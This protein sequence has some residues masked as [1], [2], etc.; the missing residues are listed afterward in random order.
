[1][2]RHPSTN[3]ARTTFN[4]VQAAHTPCA[5]PNPCMY[6]ATSGQ[7]SVQF[8]LLGCA[9]VGPISVLHTLSH[10]EFGVCLSQLC[11]ERSLTAPDLQQVTSIR[12]NRRQ[13]LQTC[14]HRSALLSS[15]A[16]SSTPTCARASPAIARAQ[17]T[18]SCLVHYIQQHSFSMQ[19]LFLTSTN[20]LRSLSRSFS[21]SSRPD[22]P[23]SSDALCCN[24]ACAQDS[25]HLRYVCDTAQHAALWRTR[26]G[27]SQ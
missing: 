21:S 22:R 2:L 27:A 5:T 1:M 18:Y 7:P 14:A 16:K 20:A 8:A 11:L 13:H 23:C 9:S 24:R 10:L 25:A 19:G 6:Q 26:S 12:H 17:V 4:N 3:G 15:Q